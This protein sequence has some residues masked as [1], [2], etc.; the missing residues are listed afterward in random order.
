MNAAPA[1][2]DLAWLNLAE[3][4]D[5]IRLR[6]LS[7]VELTRALIDRIER[8][9]LLRPLSRSVARGS[10]RVEGHHRPCR[11]ADNRAFEKPTSPG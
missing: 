4:A 7:P 6:L 8:L 11:A 3:V 2:D 9:D 10:I 1:D 5:R